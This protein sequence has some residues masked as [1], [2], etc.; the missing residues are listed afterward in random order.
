MKL[1]SYELTFTDFNK[2][3]FLSQFIPLNKCKYDIISLH[4]LCW[5]HNLTPYNHSKSRPVWCDV[6]GHK[7][8]VCVP[9]PQLVLRWNGITHDLTNRIRAKVMVSSHGSIIVKEGLL[10]GPQLTTYNHFKN[11]STQCDLEG[12]KRFECVFLITNWF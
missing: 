4:Q 6:E 7:I 12:H 2:K 11:R 9:H 1:T 10:G 3:R 5:E 8:R